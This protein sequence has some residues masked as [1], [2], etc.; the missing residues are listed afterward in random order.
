MSSTTEQ[1]EATNEDCVIVLSSGTVMTENG[2]EEEDQPPV[3][4]KNAR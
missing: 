3:L 4:S 2:T 1:A